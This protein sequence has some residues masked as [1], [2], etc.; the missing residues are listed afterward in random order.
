MQW[1]ASYA[2][3]VFS[4]ANNINTH[5][6]GTHLSGFKAALTRTLNAYARD[7]RAPQGEGREPLRRGRARGPRAIVSVKL[8]EPQFEGQTKTKLGNPSIARHRRDG[9]R[10][11]SSRSSSRRTRPSAKAIV[12]KAVEAAARPAGGPQGARPDAPQDGARATASLP[13]KLADC[14]IDRPARSASCSWSRATAPAARAEGRN[15]EFQAILPLRGKILNVEKARIDKVLS[16]DGDPGH[17][18]GHRRRHRR[19]VRHRRRP[20]TTRSWR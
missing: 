4:F 13:G 17:D 16:N 20:A 3:R 5:E 10:T 1:N 11:S 2:E 9:R 12:K 18:H 8:R 14:S 15:R 19:R 6:G 7:E